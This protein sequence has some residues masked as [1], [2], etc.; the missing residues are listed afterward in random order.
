MNTYEAK[1]LLRQSLVCLAM[2][3][4]QIR[5]RETEKCMGYDEPMQDHLAQCTTTKTPYEMSSVEDCCEYLNSLYKGFEE[6]SN[7]EIL[8]EKK[9]EMADF[10]VA[11]I[12]DMVM[13]YIGHGFPDN[14]VDCAR[15]INDVA[16]E[17]LPPYSKYIQNDKGCKKLLSLFL[18]KTDEI[19]KKH[20][21][22]T[23]NDGEYSLP[24]GYLHD[25]MRR[26]YWEKQ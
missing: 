4:E 12:C 21:L 8:M 14:L 9:F 11:H 16:D 22:Q 3:M 19:I 17:L 20:H 23:W 10:D 26:R 13:G 18:K 6:A 1:V 24:L 15:E 2:S 25:W 5:I 7:H